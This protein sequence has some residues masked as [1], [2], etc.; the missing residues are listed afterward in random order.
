MPHTNNALKIFTGHKSK[1][2]MTL[3]KPF[4][5]IRLIEKPIVINGISKKIITPLIRC[6]ID[7]IAGIGNRMVNR[8]KFLGFLLIV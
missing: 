1:I 2:D 4:E 8:F 7:T 6:I 3:A 5:D